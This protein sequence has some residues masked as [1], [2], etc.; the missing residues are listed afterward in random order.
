MEGGY[1]WEVECFRSSGHGFAGEK[2]LEGGMFVPEK[3]ISRIMEGGVLK[4]PRGDLR[5]EISAF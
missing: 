3:Q 2:R 4:S 5:L 1:K